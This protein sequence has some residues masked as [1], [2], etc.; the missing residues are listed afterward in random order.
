MAIT[1]SVN[2][3]NDP[4][5]GPVFS[6]KTYERSNAPF[7]NNSRQIDFVTWDG[8]LYVCVDNSD[9]QRGV[10]YK[11]GNPANN[12]FL[13]LIKKGEN[14]QP[15]APGAPGKPGPMPE[16]SLK[17][18][19]KQL[20]IIDQNGV[21]KAVSPEL[22]G[23]SW[24][25]ELQGHKIIWKRKEAEDTSIPQNIDLDE[26][27]PIE[28][29]PILLR[30]NSD[31]T[32]REAEKTG[33]GYYIQWKREGAD[34]WTNLMSISELMNIALAG[35][36]FWWDDAKDGSTD[37][38]GNP[39]Q[40]L[41]FGHKQVIEATYDASKLGNK[42]IADV[43]LGDVLFDAGEIPFA[44]YD[45]DIAALNAY[46]C[47]LQ[48]DLTAT[49]ASIPT[50][51]SQLINDV[52]YIKTVNGHHPNTAGELK[53]KTVDNIDLVG[54]SNIPF[55]KIN[56]RP[57]V[58][59]EANFEIPS[60][61]LTA[62]NLKTIAGQ[63]LIKGSDS[64]GNI[65]LRTVNGEFLIG[66]APIN[67][68]TVRSVSVNGGTHVTPDS[69][70]N[71]NLTVTDSGSGFR[72]LDDST[73]PNDDTNSVANA[74]TIY[75]IWKYIK[76]EFGRLWDRIEECCSGGIDPDPGEQ[77]Y[78]TITPTSGTHN[79][80]SGNDS[81]Q[82]YSNVRWTA[83]GSSITITSGSNGS[84]N[85]TI[86]FSFAQNN[87]SGTVLKWITV[88]AVDYPEL[89]ATYNLTQ[90]GFPTLA[91]M[92]SHGSG[93]DD[94]GSG[95]T[96]LQ[97]NVPWTLSV[98]DSGGI[99]PSPT[100]GNIGNTTI[101][102][103]YTKNSST[104][105]RDLTI[106]ALGRDGVATPAVYTF[107]QAGKSSTPD[108]DPTTPTINPQVSSIELDELG[109]TEC[110]NVNVSGNGTWT[111]S[112][113]GSSNWLHSSKNGN[114]VC[115]TADPNL[116]G[117]C[118]DGV[119]DIC[120]G[121]T[122]AHI[123]VHQCYA[124]IEAGASTINR[125]CNSSN[126]SIRVNGTSGWNYSTSDSWIHPTIT[127][128]GLS[129]NIDSNNSGTDRSGS[130][131]VYLTGANSITDTITINQAKCSDPGGEDCTEISA[132]PT[133]I[134]LS[135]DGE[136]SESSTITACD[137]W[138]YEVSSDSEWLHVDIDGDDLVF[139]ASTNRN[140]DRSATIT[141][142]LTNNED[143][144]DTI[145]VEQDEYVDT[146][147]ETGDCEGE[148]IEVDNS[149]VSLSPSGDNGVSVDITATGEWDYT[150]SSDSEWLEIDR[151][152]NTLTFSASENCDSDHSV[153]VTV[154]LTDCQN[155]E[156]NIYVGQ[157]ARSISIVSTGRDNFGYR[158]ESGSIP[159]EAN[160][161]WTAS[162]SD[163]WITITGTTNTDLTQTGLGSVSYEVSQ[164]DGNN[165]REGYITV[166]SN[167]NGCSVSDSRDIWQNCNINPPTPPV[168][169]AEISLSPNTIEF[170]CGKKINGSDSETVTVTITNSSNH[171]GIVSD[172]PDWINIS[173]VGN[174]TFDVSIS[175]SATVGLQDHTGTIT[176]TINGEE[177]PSG[178]WPT[179][180]VI[181]D[182]IPE[183]TDELMLFDDPDASDYTERID[184][185]YSSH[186]LYVGDCVTI[187]PRAWR[188]YEYPGQGTIYS[189]Y[190]DAYGSWTISDSSCMSGS[191]G[192]FCAEAPTGSN[193]VT[194][195]FT[196]SN[197][198]SVESTSMTYG[199]SSPYYDIQVAT[200]DNSH[201]S[202]GDSISLSGSMTLNNGSA[203]DHTEDSQYDHSQPTH[204]LNITNVSSDDNCVD[205]SGTTLTAIGSGSA[206][207]TVEFEDGSSISFTVNASPI[208]YMAYNLNETNSVSYDPLGST[209]FT[210]DTGNDPFV[211]GFCYGQDYNNPADVSIS[212]PSISGS[213]TSHIQAS[214]SGSEIS[215][216]VS[217]EA[218]GTVEFDV[219][220]STITFNVNVSA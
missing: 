43:T 138:S 36:C 165:V 120:I 53:L 141:V 132:S 145:T 123:S 21:R 173:N 131:T 187:Y 205:V 136:G 117:S 84:N 107:T 45:D 60:D 115:I 183:H 212:G 88:T 171:F 62:R 215:I 133:S 74:R 4:K 190:V 42:R 15:G 166:T 83:T 197:L 219:D 31:N 37:I 202:N 64:D 129:I 170:D 179:I 50:K 13:L 111:A 24:F 152:G 195:E 102:F 140:G 220:G 109:G 28:E 204:N 56:G 67:V 199:I 157:S 110:I 5:L 22:T 70:G 105:S 158:S 87:S 196:S 35:V 16:Y 89:T 79:F 156:A 1:R 159:V 180:S 27:R 104:S 91:F 90:S 143:I 69:N 121:S 211:V 34:E 172:Y 125:S 139:S 29:C 18:D 188:H 73:K 78:L 119:V 149:S 23:P 155:T 101:N 182:G 81:I 151:S 100:S 209:S 19:G 217:G 108:V 144:Y 12:G 186:Q 30:L 63:S 142:Y 80:T 20:V 203:K 112:V 52:P 95:S 51:V 128:N 38:N 135:P 75:E 114:Q 118:R 178:G 208:V 160:V 97:A 77:P 33:P 167:D 164:N 7:F 96:V 191:D 86:E 39:V 25:P 68:G 154:Y 198:S 213:S 176:V 76:S 127:S 200:T 122:C 194:V 201:I 137:D 65:S 210:I 57:I 163:S 192:S 150:T 153:T 185:A 54:E 10:S 14:G 17:F 207:I 66:T 44:N 106:T 189:D 174:D 116:T 184:G 92:P 206:S 59:T 126:I 46:L 218:N 99:F 161:P 98:A 103:T 72:N 181:W 11:A 8:N 146:G 3:A 61:Y 113:A 82:V 49:K 94:S 175:S 148:S 162:A 2:T 214:A 193:G 32:K 58:N 85:G 6:F 168:E 41:H 93:S 40:T 216:D 26:L 130:I 169:A 55:A 9:P 71:V 177:E 47:D 134:T 48:D 147:S 124:D